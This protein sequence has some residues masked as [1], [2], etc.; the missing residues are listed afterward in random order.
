MEGQYT[1]SV[2]LCTSVSAQTV[3][4]LQVALVV[5]TIKHPHSGRH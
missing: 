1:V 5:P 3:L 2:M 4:L